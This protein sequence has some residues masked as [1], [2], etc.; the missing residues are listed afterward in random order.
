LIDHIAGMGLRA[1]EYT[2]NKRFI[3]IL[4]ADAWCNQYGADRGGDKTE[5][6]LVGVGVAPTL[7]AYSCA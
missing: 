3:R 1:N 7:A 4:P 6:S 2:V 5:N